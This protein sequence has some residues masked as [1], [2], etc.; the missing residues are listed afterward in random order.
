MSIRQLDKTFYYN[1][2]E[3]HKS[4]YATNVASTLTNNWQTR[5]VRSDKQTLESFGNPTY[6]W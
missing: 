6:C 4:L 1:L 5:A 3:T 2:N